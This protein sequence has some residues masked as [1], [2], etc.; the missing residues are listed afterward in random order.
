MD[1]LEGRQHG[2]IEL[3]D[4][5]ATVDGEGSEPSE[6]P[7]SPTSP[8]TTR[9]RGLSS[10]SLDSEGES[11]GAAEAARLEPA[12]PE[13]I[14]VFPDYNRSDY[15]KDYLQDLLNRANAI[16][17]MSVDT[18]RLMH[19]KM[20]SVDDYLDGYY[21]G[22][23]SAATRA[24]FDGGSGPVRE[25]IKAKFKEII[26]RHALGQE[27]AFRTVADIESLMP[28][29]IKVPVS[30]RNALADL[31]R[32]MPEV[33]EL[34]TQL[35]N[36]VRSGR[37]EGGIKTPEGLMEIS[38]LVTMIQGTIGS[39]VMDLNGF[40]GNDESDARFSLVAQDLPKAIE[41]L[42]VMINTQFSEDSLDLPSIRFGGTGSSA[43][44]RFE[45]A[46]GAF[47][48]L[49]ALGP[50]GSVDDAD[51]ERLLEKQKVIDAAREGVDIP[52]AEFAPH[53]GDDQMSK[54][55]HSS[56]SYQS[57]PTD[58]HDAPLV[59]TR[60]LGLAF[61]DRAQVKSIKLDFRALGDINIEQARVLMETYETVT[62]ALPM[63]QFDEESQNEAMNKRFKKKVRAL[64]DSGLDE[65]QIEK[66]KRVMRMHIRWCDQAIYAMHAHVMHLDDADG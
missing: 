64:R 55:G 40:H 39:R 16:N 25:A 48:R 11:K 53:G 24:W 47:A 62:R 20:T 66:A 6:G 22:M 14:E 7:E 1:D 27:L 37:E 8:A 18:A 10:V 65:M 36:K 17:D 26:E 49:L 58:E 23:R 12:K 15:P 60:N 4:L 45:G 52:E 34:Y 13:P 56:W 5:P 43:T 32:Q 28:G 50:A 21:V 31:F 46:K 61:G 63:Q 35:I 2:D 54:L 44:E 33:A 30:Y 59:L 19:D 51:F 3:R 9:S 42:A 38:M 57:E 41:E 29:Q